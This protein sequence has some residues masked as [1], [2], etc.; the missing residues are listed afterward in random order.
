MSCKYKYKDNWYSK[1]EIKEILLKERGVNSKGELIKPIITNNPKQ[2]EITKENTTS[3]ESVLDNYNKNDRYIPSGDVGYVAKDDL[4]NITDV[5]DDIKKAENQVKLWQETNPDDGWRVEKINKP[6]EKEYTSQ[7][8]INLKVAALKEVAKKY[9]RS[10]ITSRVVPI[11]P[12]L[13][14][15]SEIQYSKKGGVKP[16]VQE[17]FESN[18]ELANAVYSKLLANSGISAENLLSL[19]LKDNIIEKKC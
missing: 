19:L 2:A 6:K 18:P 14:G 4:G 5:F 9:P 16:G 1:E 7:A 13:V 8:L 15:S 3:I 12:N 17:L 11:N 10:L